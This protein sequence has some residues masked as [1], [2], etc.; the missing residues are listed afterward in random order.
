MI[1]KEELL[2]LLKRGLDGEEKAIPIYT[3]HLK[4]AVFWAGMKEKE[5]QEARRILERLATESVGHKKIVNGLIDS[6]E[7][8]DKDAF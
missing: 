1:K 4:S 8:S 3:Q 2:E 5:A 6:V 7:R